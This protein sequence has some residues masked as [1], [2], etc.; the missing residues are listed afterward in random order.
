MLARQIGA[1]LT[2]VN[3]VDD[4][5][6]QSLIDLER[7]EA[8]KFLKEQIGSL[9]ELRDVRC[10]A[11]TTTGEAFMGILQTAKDTACDLIVMGSHRKQLLRDVFIGTTIE[12]VIRTGSFP[13]L[14]VNKPT[15]YGYHRIVAAID[16]SDA[17]ARAIKAAEALHLFDRAEV[18]L[19]HAF[20][21]PAQGKMF[22]SNA[23]KEQMEAYVDDERTQAAVELAAFMVTHG[24][25]AGRWRRRLAEGGPFEVIERVVA[26]EEPDLLITG[27]HG[28]SG[29]L[30]VLIGSVAE[31]ILRRLDVDILAVPPER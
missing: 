10:H 28:R 20:L 27:T 11:V 12:R 4:D 30:K 23:S 17:S 25:G 13:V 1:E 22:V 16:L 15:D 24:L 26:D 18:T 9:A 21:A 6:P 29:L 8:D 19:L 5:Q 2:L 3:V 7:R 31:E 14:M